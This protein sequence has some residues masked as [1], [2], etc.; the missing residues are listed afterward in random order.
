MTRQIVVTHTIRQTEVP[1]LLQVELQTHLLSKCCSH[2]KLPSL[3]FSLKITYVCYK[4]V[5][6]CYETFLF[7]EPCY[8]KF[9]YA[10]ILKKK[11]I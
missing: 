2:K 4:I 8:Y 1:V 11:T 5:Y 9:L 6:L 10:L 7:P 3:T